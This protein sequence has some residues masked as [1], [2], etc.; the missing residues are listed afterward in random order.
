[1]NWTGKLALTNLTFGKWK[2]TARSTAGEVFSVAQLEMNKEMERKIR[3]D[4]GGG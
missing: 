1:M 4:C 2:A 3:G